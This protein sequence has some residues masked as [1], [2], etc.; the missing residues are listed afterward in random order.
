MVAGSRTTF[1]RS[2]AS[3][4]VEPCAVACRGPPSCAC[5]GA[6]EYANPWPRGQ[7]GLHCYHLLPSTWPER[8]SLCVCWLLRRLPGPCSG[9]PLGT[10]FLRHASSVSSIHAAVCGVYAHTGTRHPSTWMVHDLLPGSCLGWVQGPVWGP[11]LYL[12]WSV[13]MSRL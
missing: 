3:T 13:V 6:G 4:Y 7:S 12:S 8:S 9:S 2:H 1:Q 11:G 5:R 10:L